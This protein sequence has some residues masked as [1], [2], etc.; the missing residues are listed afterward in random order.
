MQ[1]LKSR[2]WYT[3]STKGESDPLNSKSIDDEVV[4]NFNSDEDDGKSGSWL[5]S[6]SFFNWMYKPQLDVRV[7]KIR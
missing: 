1:R 4:I 5:R 7:N 2:L 3:N 6:S